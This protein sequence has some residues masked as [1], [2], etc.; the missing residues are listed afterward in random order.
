MEDR[1]GLYILLV[2][3]GIAVVGVVGFALWNSGAVAGSGVVSAPCKNAPGIPSDLPCQVQLDYSHRFRKGQKVKVNVEMGMSAIIYRVPCYGT[4]MLGYRLDGG[5]ITTICSDFGVLDKKY[6][7]V[8]W[9]VYGLRKF[10]TNLKRWVWA[11]EY[12]WVAEELL[13][14]A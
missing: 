7:K 5:D 2:L 3:L 6:N 9:L 1:T 14:E 12:G 13:T 4:D 11:D 8:F 10:D